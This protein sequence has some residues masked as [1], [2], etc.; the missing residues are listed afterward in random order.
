VLDKVNKNIVLLEEYLPDGVA[1]SIWDR[2]QD[3]QVLF[4]IS[5]PRKSKLGDYRPPQK[6]KGHRISVNADL[7][8]FSF[9]ITVLHEFAH[10][11]TWKKYKN[12]KKP[13]GPEWKG[14]FQGVLNPYLSEEVFPESVN[15]ALTHYIANPSASSCVDETLMRALA[16]HDLVKQ[17]FV[18]DVPEGTLFKLS[19][20]LVF[21]KG[22]KLRK[23]FKC[24]CV[25]NNRWYFVSPTASAIQIPTQTKLF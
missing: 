22:Q 4:R 24:K 13:H 6:Q 19:N 12:N 17:L 5:K 16:H 20:G 18:E 10:L 8:P 9:L 7:N 3:D 11:E 25:T 15:T 2:I 21:E 23:R 1:Q 14:E